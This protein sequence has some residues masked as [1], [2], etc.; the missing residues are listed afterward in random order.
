M[1]YPKM[2]EALRARAAAVFGVAPSALRGLP[3]DAELAIEPD[4]RVGQFSQLEAQLMDGSGRTLRAFVDTSGRVCTWPD[5]L[6]PVLVSSG[7]FAQPPAMSPQ[8]LAQRLAWAMGRE[9]RLQ[10]GNAPIPAAS[11][12]GDASKVGARALSFVVSRRQA[13]P[14][15]AGGGPVP[16]TA[17]SV[18]LS[19]DG[20]ATITTAPVR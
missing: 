1:D 15:G 17:V 10:S 7:A 11:L 8:A 20:V 3:V 19:S 4:R 5:A 12:H 18:A 9:V 16:N 2:Q 14:G 13:G 6:G